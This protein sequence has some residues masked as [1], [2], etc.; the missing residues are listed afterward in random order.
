MKVLVTEYGAVLLFVY[1]SLFWKTQNSSAKR[2]TPLGI[3]VVSRLS[4]LASII[5]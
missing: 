4:S 2:G 5:A 1:I 3:S